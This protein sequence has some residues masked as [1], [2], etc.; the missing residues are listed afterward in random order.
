MIEF[1]LTLRERTF[2]E[3][4]LAIAQ[5]TTDVV[6][7]KEECSIIECGH[8]VTL[9]TGDFVNVKRRHVFI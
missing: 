4:S 8:A 1:K 9:T 5:L 3:T 6:T 2:I 7:P